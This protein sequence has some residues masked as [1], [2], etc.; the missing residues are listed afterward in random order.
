MVE[1][2]GKN[3][4]RF[5]TPK[6]AFDAYKVAHVAQ[7]G[8]ESEFHPDHPIDDSHLYVEE[9]PA[10][11]E[12]TADGQYKASI[13]HNKKSRYIGTFN[14]VEEASA[15]YQAEKERIGR[16]IM[17]SK[18]DLPTGVFKTSSGKYRAKTA[19]H[20]IGTFNTVEEASAAFQQTHAPKVSKEAKRQAA[21]QARAEAPAPKLAWAA[22]VAKARAARS[23]KEAARRQAA[24]ERYGD[25]EL[26]TGVRMTRSAKFKARI[27]TGKGSNKIET[28]LGVF[29]T[30]DEAFDAYKRAHVEYNGRASQYFNEMM[31]A[32]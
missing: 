29:D 21:L 12:I 8:V 20:H 26:P 9:L 25:I 6:K 3:L 11:V 30:P 28:H 7:Y 1:F 4:G 13:S 23:I 17:A 19:D 32:A 18:G 14:T 24:L 2:R 31:E 22:N 10:G 5:P 16:P 15:A 27:K